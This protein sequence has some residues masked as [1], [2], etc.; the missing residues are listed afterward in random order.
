MTLLV[1][2]SLVAVAWVAVTGRTGEVLDRVTGSPD[3]VV[4]PIVDGGDHDPLGDGWEH[5]DRVPAAF[6]GDP[7]TAW[8][9]ERYDRA[10]L[11]PPAKDGVGMWVTIEEAARVTSVELV[12]GVAGAQV[13]VYVGDQPPAPDAAPADLGELVASGTVGAPS[14]HVELDPGAQG[15]VVLLWF[16][17]LAPVEGGFRASVAELELRGHPEGR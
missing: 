11:I 10:D 6:D 1:T 16:T 5:P 3:P 14:W 9:S 12:P 13:E 7:T 17:E 2:A 8:T 4:L 15:R